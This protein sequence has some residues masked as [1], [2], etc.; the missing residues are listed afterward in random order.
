MSQPSPSRGRRD[1]DHWYHGQ[2]QGDS[3]CCHRDGCVGPT[4]EDRKEDTSRERLQPYISTLRV[5][6]QN[7]IFRGLSK[8]VL[9]HFFQESA[10]FACSHAYTAPQ[11]TVE[12]T[13]GPSQLKDTLSDVTQVRL[14]PKALTGIL[15][16]PCLC[17]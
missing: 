14:Y 9:H 7:G 3:Q 15:L 5:R 12:G 4:Q 10:V 13:M 11:P 17:S 1:V 6:R 8:N 2:Q 16:L